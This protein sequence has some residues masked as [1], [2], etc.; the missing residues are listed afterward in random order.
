ML[1][2]RAAPYRNGWAVKVAGE[3]VVGKIGMRFP[4]FLFYLWGLISGRWKSGKGFLFFSFRSPPSSIGKQ[5]PSGG[6]FSQMEL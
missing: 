6:I 3:M 4:L 5:Q 1:E 2:D